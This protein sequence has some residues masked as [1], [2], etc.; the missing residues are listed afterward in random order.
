[1]I[2]TSGASGGQKFHRLCY[3]SL[4]SYTQCSLLELNICSNSLDLIKCVHS[5]RPAASSTT[6]STDEILVA[7]IWNAMNG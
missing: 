4:G 5:E 6:L 7:Q 2:A 1:M 3:D